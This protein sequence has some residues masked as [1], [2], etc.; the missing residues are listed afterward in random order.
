MIYL[1]ILYLLLESTYYKYTYL[2]APLGEVQLGKKEN[3]LFLHFANPT[4]PLFVVHCT[5]NMFSGQTQ[6][7]SVKPVGYKHVLHVKLYRLHHHLLLIK[8]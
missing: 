8:M 2:L 4:E 6:K 5:K 1:Q 3:S 7:A